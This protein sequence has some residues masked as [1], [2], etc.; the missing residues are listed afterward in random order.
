MSA[1][2][3]GGG[4]VTQEIFLEGT[5]YA[6]LVLRNGN[7]L[8]PLNSKKDPEGELL[9][10]GNSLARLV[11]LAPDG[12]IVWDRYYGDLPGGTVYGLFIELEDG[13]LAGLAH[14]YAGAAEPK[15]WR[16]TLSPTGEE[17]ARE[18]Q[19]MDWFDILVVPGGY[20]TMK[21]NPPD[22]EWEYSYQTPAF[23]TRWS[24]S[25]TQAVR[26]QCWAVEG[27]QGGLLLLGRDAERESTTAVAKVSYDGELIWRA[28]L[29]DGTSCGAF[30]AQ[31]GTVVVLGTITNPHTEERKGYT[32]G[33]SREGQIL[34]EG[35]YDLGD[36]FRGFRYS[37]ET[38]QGHRLLYL[39][40]FGNTNS[41]GKTLHSL[42]LDKTG[43]ELDRREYQHPW[44]YANTMAGLTVYN[45]S[46]VDWNG[47]AWVMV[48]GIHQQGGPDGTLM[49]RLDMNSLWE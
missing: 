48:Y 37:E 13:N 11:C 9:D 2:A 43:R 42:L 14:Y 32:A 4:I 31:D 27:V 5:C 28:G 8:L 17:I 45:L 39:S 6:P 33:I 30:E 49:M 10:K 23:E 18:P 3:L 29:R 15:A 21:N 12:T 1:P 26:Y 46:F 7:L 36:D 19:P 34:W 35:E 20:W 25:E 24:I 47:Q 22:G 38:P 16:L 44:D 40:D 41:E